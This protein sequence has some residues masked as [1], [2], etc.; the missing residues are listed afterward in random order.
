M[1]PHA[2]GSGQPYQK[3]TVESESEEEENDGDDPIVKRLPIYYTPHYLNS[4]TL[5]QYPDRPPR[6][7]TQHPLLP[8]SLRPGADPAPKPERSQI[9]A[10]YKPQTGHLELEVPIEMHPDRWNPDTAEKFGEGLV[11]DQAEEGKGKKKKKSAAAA[12]KEAEKEGDKEPKRLDRMV[13]SSLSVPDVT[14]YLI[15]VVKD[16]PSRLALPGPWF[17]S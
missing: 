11:D 4:L 2:S 12:E 8:P 13:Y 10:R 5:L 15:G 17:V 1:P 7:H 3:P 6:P 14:N 9:N 16:G